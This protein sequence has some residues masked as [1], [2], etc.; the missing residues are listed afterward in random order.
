MEESYK[1]FAFISYSHRDEKWA[2]FIQNEL[3]GYKLPNV[4]RKEAKRELPKRIHPVFRDATDLG[5]GLLEDNLKAELAASKY[6]IVICSPNSASENADGKCWVDNEVHYYARELKRGSRI[7]PII[8]EGTPNEAFCKTLKEIGCLAL[9]ASKHHKAR[10]VNDIVAK[11]LGL[12]PDDLWQRELRRRCKQRLIKICAAVLVV[13]VSALAGWYWWDWNREQ[14]VYC[15]D[16]VDKYGLPH[17]LDTISRDSLKGCH[18]SYRLHY[19]GYDTFWLGMRKQILRR[20]YCVNSSDQIVVSD[21][22]L[23]NHART[24]GWRFDYGEHGNLVEVRH[25]S[26]SGMDVGIFRYSG[27]NADVVDVLKRGHNGRWGSP[28][29][30]LGDDKE[31][32]RQYRLERDSNGFVISKTYM[33][34][35]KGTKAKDG[36]GV[37][38]VKYEV[39]LLGRVISMRQYEWDGT[40]KKINDCDEIRLEYSSNGN[41]S[42][43]S[44]VLTNQIV[45]V[46]CFEYDQ[47]GNMIKERRMN[48]NG[49]LIKGGWC[50]K[51][52]LVDD[53]GNPLKIE[54]FDEERILHNFTDAKTLRSYEY[55][56]GRIMSLDESY[57]NQKESMGKNAEGFSRVCQKFDEYGNVIELCRY[58][59][60]GKLLHADEGNPVVGVPP[61]IIRKKYDLCQREIW[62]GLF[63]ADGKPMLG[64]QGWAAR[65]TLWA[66]DYSEK[67][68]RHYGID[69]QAIIRTE[70][71]DCAVE[72]CCFD[73]SG[74]IKSSVLY[75]LNGE[76][77]ACRYGWHETRFKYDRLGFLAEIS[78]FDVDGKPVLGSGFGGYDG[79]VSKMQFVNDSNGNQ[80]EISYWGLDGKLMNISRGYAIVRQKFDGNNRCVEI[81]LFDS[82]NRLVNPIGGDNARTVIEYAANGRKCKTLNYSVNGERTDIEFD[83]RGHHVSESYYLPNG[84]PA[85]D[86][87][88][89]AKLVY[90]YDKNGREVKRGF[91]GID[92]RRA[93]SEDRIAGWNKKYDAQG[94]CIE[95]S[96]FG[97]DG[98]ISADNNGVAIV[99]WEFD[100]EGN[101]LAK[102][103]FDVA[104]NM[105]INGSGH[106]GVRFK[107]DSNGNK[108]EEYSIGLD[109]APAIDNNGVHIVKFWYD[110]VRRI[111][112]REFYDA[113]YNRV[114]NKKGIGG[115]ASE[116]DL[117]G[118]EIKRMW[119][120][121]RGE[122]TMQGNEG[123]GWIYKYDDKGRL[124]EES[125]LDSDWKSIITIKLT[126]GSAKLVAKAV[127]YTYDKIGRK[128]A[129]VKAAVK[130]GACGGDAFSVLNSPDGDI[131]EMRVLDENGG[132]VDGDL[133]WARKTIEYND[134]REPTC[135]TYWDKVGNPAVFSETGTHRGECRYR[136]TENGLVIETHNFGI[137]G[138]PVTDKKSGFATSIIAYD[139]FYRLI[140]LEMFDHHGSPIGINGTRLSKQTITYDGCGRIGEVRFFAVDGKALCEDGTAGF[141]FS[142]FDDHVDVTALNTE[143]EGVY[144]KKVSL[145]EGIAFSRKYMQKYSAKISNPYMK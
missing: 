19:Q 45:Q 103:F 128:T 113:A 139:R 22:A 35:V 50:E 71:P 105:A 53:E 42:K 33:R 78:Y 106:A 10:I 108:I 75:G 129:T 25:V 142:Y 109:G 92:G 123:Y 27:D 120:D 24:A 76:K 38:Q 144:T 15:R 55:G 17:P 13:A 48:A 21:S 101:M 59:V 26:L 87:N 69:G 2:K 107:Y 3:E 30:I 64:E 23:P 130:G 5:V 60:D 58:G 20:M 143:W 4:I 31:M 80:L 104:T 100:G 79:Y 127:N 62:I 122:P 111:T 125:H 116:Y 74:R 97:L 94:N 51:H 110:D 77:I 9:D 66:K 131:L 88:G 83:D 29:R 135:E 72:K 34:D 63:D 8:I 44:L 49:D 61:A 112:R 132:L 137:K 136:R 126:I 121:T 140:S 95:E 91:M 1:Y 32:I 16:Y 98:Q 84:D 65:E 47:N 82:N 118:H 40:L 117:N 134:Y 141:R 11:I 102:T 133:G 41:L 145:E 52:I 124:V 37:S 70:K 115:W 67:T 93:L 114:L 46:S 18:Q 68:L 39:D 57:F 43:K 7:I 81:E 85:A 14:I 119:F 90:K 54:F 6:L 56:D 138:F 99:R 96:Y 73:Q 89:V 12:K 28:A 86:K 36:T